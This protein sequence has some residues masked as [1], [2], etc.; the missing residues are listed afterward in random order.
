VTWTGDR[1]EFLGRNGTLEHP[2]RA[3][4]GAAPLSNRVGAGSIPA[5][6]CSAVELAPGETAE[7]VFFLG[8]AA[9][10]AARA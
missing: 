3:G 2:R 8:E 5:A 9:S 6:R 4:G 7:I 10:A 1:R